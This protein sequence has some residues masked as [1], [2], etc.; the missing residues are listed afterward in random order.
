MEKDEGDDDDEEQHAGEDEGEREEGG[1][2]HGV[3]GS[4]AGAKI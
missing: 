3:C 2:L 4:V 1:E